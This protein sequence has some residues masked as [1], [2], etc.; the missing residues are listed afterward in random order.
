MVMNDSISG[1][2][3]VI[4]YAVTTDEELANCMKQIELAQT[5]VLGFVLNDVHIKR[6]TSNHYYRK[7][8]YSKGGYGYGYGYGYG[9]EPELTLEDEKEAK[10]NSKKEDKKEEPQKDD[11]DKK[12]IKKKGKGNKNA[13]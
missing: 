3:L 5:N 4:R 10:R 6:N 7:Y 9:S 1:L 11:S 12:N 13:G 8:G 2:L